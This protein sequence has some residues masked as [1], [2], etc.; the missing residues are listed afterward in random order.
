MIGEGLIHLRGPLRGVNQVRI[1]IDQMDAPCGQTRVNIHSTQINGEEAEKLEIVANR[2][3]TYIDQA[4]FLTTQSGEL[5]RKA[6]VHAASMRA[7]EARGLYPGETQADRDQRYMYAFFGR[8]FAD[9][10]RAMD[11]EFL[12]SETNCCH[13]TRWT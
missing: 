1:M 3:Q 5:L 4:R 8:D 6:V 2:I 9:E 13:C 12:R 10:L 7:E 11:S